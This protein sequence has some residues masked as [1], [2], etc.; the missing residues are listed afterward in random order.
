MARIR[1]EEAY[2]DTRS[3]LLNVGMNLIRA[4]SYESVGIND[5]LRASGVPK[6]SFY[7]YFQSNYSSKLT[8]KGSYDYEVRF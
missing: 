7:H 5:V 1:N 8:P 3:K 4:G 6:G 2:H